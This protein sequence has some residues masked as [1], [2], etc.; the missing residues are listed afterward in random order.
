ML[1]ILEEHEAVRTRRPETRLRRIARLTESLTRSLLQQLAVVGGLPDRIGEDAP[2]VGD[3]IEGLIGEGEAVDGGVE[4]E[5][6]PA[7]LSRDV[8]GALSRTAEPEDGV[9]VGEVGVG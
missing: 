8:L 1:R 4:E 2:G 7:V 6:E 3:E 9:P 5:R